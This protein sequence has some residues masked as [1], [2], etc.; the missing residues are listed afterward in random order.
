MKNFKHE[1]NIERLKKKFELQIQMQNKTLI[2]YKFV[3]LNNIRTIYINRRGM[4]V[5]SFVFGHD[6]YLIGNR[7]ISHFRKENTRTYS[8]ISQVIR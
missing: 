7:D 2:R 8:I 3:G 6:N 4:T 5:F 1:N